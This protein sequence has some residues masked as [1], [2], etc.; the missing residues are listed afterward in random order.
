M[1]RHPRRAGLAFAL[2]LPVGA[3]CAEATPSSDSIEDTIRAIRAD[4]AAIQG[5]RLRTETIDFAAEDEPLVGTLTRS[6]DGDVVVKIHLSYGLGDHGASDEFFYYRHGHL[7]FVH[8]TDGAWSFTG[9]TLA[10]GS[11]ETIDTIVEHRVYFNAGQIIRHLR[12]EAWSTDPAALPAR[13]DQAPNRPA[14]TV[15][16]QSR[17][18]QLMLHGLHAYRVES[19]DDLEVLPLMP[20]S[21][22]HR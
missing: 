2:L 12:K 18:E 1:H 20:H 22:T 5:Q 21:T 7:F 9:R 3:L 15:A 14:A 8:A 19:R 11:S 10:D 13:L 17:A 6:L 16:D 4:Y